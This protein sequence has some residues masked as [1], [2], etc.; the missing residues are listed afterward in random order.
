[1]E[2]IKHILGI[3]GESH[4]NLIHIAFILS[5]L[6][7]TFKLIQ[8]QKK[9]IALL[10]MF[11]FV[12]TSA[13]VITQEPLKKKRT[14]FNN[15]YK[16]FFK[17]GTLYLAGDASN[18]YEQQRKD[19]FVR[20]NPENLYDVPQVIDQTIY[21][22]FDYRIGF[23]FRKLARFN[24]EIKAKHYYDGTENNKSLSAPTAAVKG[25]EYLLHFEKE[26][27]RGETFTNSRYFIRHTGKNHIVKLEQREQGNVGFK[28]QSAEARLR[29]PIGKKFSIS[30]GIIARTHQKAYGY[31]PIEIWLNETDSYTDSQGNVFEY[32]VN[33]WYTLGFMYG[34][35]DI[36][37]TSTDQNGNEMSD[38]YWINPEGETVAYTDLQFRDEIFG[39]LMNRYNNEIWDTLD[40]Y[41]EY[42]PIVGFDFYHQKGNKFWLHSYVNWILPYHTY[43][44]GDS[45]FNYLNR[46]NW[47]IGGLK[48]DSSPEQWSDYQA[49]FIMG[50]KLSRTLGFFVEGEYTKFWD[51][52]IFNTSA[53]INFRL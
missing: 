19:Y 1:M 13:Q 47:G 9:L 46:N 10:F 31:N 30:G 6:Y 15:I 11:V 5:V 49:G 52:E 14:F 26:R 28:Y 41:A 12:G 37:Y 17:Y 36:Y 48:E 21:H 53:G 16:E 32:P 39:G 22:P 4:L 29:L 18:S 3:C 45:D 50:W 23:G 20:T 8:K 40:P 2:T 25:F 27:R 51:S 34:Y 38:W 7:F 42:A 35:D 24:Y 44:K 43:F 33:P